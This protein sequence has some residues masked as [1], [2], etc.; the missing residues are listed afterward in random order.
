MISENTG[1]HTALFQMHIM[2][3]ESEM[4]CETF[5]S[6]VKAINFSNSNIKFLFCLNSQTYIE[7]PVV[8][9]AKDM[10]DAFLNHELFKTQHVDIIHKT[11]EDPF[12]NIGDWRRE[13]YNDE[14]KYIIWGESDTLVPT[15]YFKIVDSI[16]IEEPHLLSLGS[17]KMWDDT[18]M[19]VEH[20]LLRNLK[21]DQDKIGIFGCGQYISLNQ[22]NMFNSLTPDI[23]IVRLKNPKIDGSMLALSKNLPRPFISPNL[24]FGGE[25]TCAAGFFQ[26]KG[27]P[28]YVIATRLK[29]H[30]YN[31]PKKRINT[32]QNR[33]NEE[34]IEKNKASRDEMMDFL[35]KLL[36]EKHE[37]NKSDS[38]ESQ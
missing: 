32:E 37:K 2:W 19:G 24:H 38:S 7:K 22:V 23:R 14:Y 36:K 11:D 9:K 33:N 15:D 12:Y 3:Y 20:E 1:N 29:G 26:I 13:I 34:Y 18:W 8:G 6:I 25:D 21:G 31:H 27:I 4:L 35:M 17:R 28:Q 16:N 10:F 5:D 30:N